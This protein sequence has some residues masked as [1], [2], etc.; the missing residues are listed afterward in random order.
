MKPVLVLIAL[1]VVLTGCG[2]NNDQSAP[3]LSVAQKLV[4]PPVT[5]E[6]RKAEAV[7]GVK[8]SATESKMPVVRIDL[9]NLSGYKI[10]DLYA[11]YLGLQKKKNRKA[12]ALSTP[13]YVDV[14][15]EERMAHLYNKKV[16]FER[17]K[18]NGNCKE[19]SDTVLA[20]M[21]ILY[22]NYIDGDKQK[23]SIKT[24]VSI[25]DVKVAK[26]KKSLDWG[27]VCKHY[28]HTKDVKQ[29]SLKKCELLKAVVARIAGKDMVA[30]GMTELLPSAEGRLNVL[31]LDILLQNAGAEFLYHVPAL[32]DELASLGFYQFTMYA[33]RKDD[34]A[35]EG[36]SI[37][38]AFV[39]DGGEKIH[40]S[41]VY[42]K[43]H[44][45]HV[46]AFYFAVHN[47]SRMIFSLS[48]KGVKTLS[49]KHRNYQD[50]MV[51]YVAAAH[52][53]PGAAHK[54]TVRWINGGLKSNL[55]SVYR[56][57]RIHQY[58]VKTKNNLLAL[59]EKK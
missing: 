5:R 42:L 35:T 50:E 10:D 31:Y 17:C 36:A 43:G 56:G 48:E 52:H 34:E 37:V 12:A 40:D 58:A 25:A 39:K 11:D 41:V 49:V 30:Y 2:K 26:A 33:L 47:L 3:S 6:E 7:E 28:Q 14:S 57:H 24:F 4:T 18:K 9:S 44:E 16:N 15:F 54:K 27:R 55:F 53:A 32:G 22:K 1:V 19:A 23:M 29:L 46:A 13:H 45:H 59:Y 21:P 38:N 8:K 20:Q 51:M